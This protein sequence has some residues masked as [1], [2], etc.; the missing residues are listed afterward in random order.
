M[1]LLKH[2]STR[3]L[4]YVKRYVHLA[5]LLCLM[6]RDCIVSNLLHLMQA[7]KNAPP[8]LLLDSSGRAIDVHGNLAISKPIATAKVC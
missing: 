5:T 3:K 1:P 4:L 6:G 8:P 2:K 7:S